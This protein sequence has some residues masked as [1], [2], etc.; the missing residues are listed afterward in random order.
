MKSLPLVILGALCVTLTTAPWAEAQEEPSTEETEL[1]DRVLAV[2]DED[3]ILES[4][5]R[6][7][8]GLGLAEPLPEEEPEA[9]RRRLLDALV[10]QKLRFHEIDRYGFAQIPL[11]EVEEQFDALRER[12]GGEKAMAER[13]EELELDEEG[14]RQLLARQLMVLIYVEERLGPRVL[15]G[16]A[17][18]QKYYD[19]TLVPELRQRRASVPPV[20]E[21]REE[22]RELLRQQRLNDEIDLWTEE[23]RVEADIEDYLD[24]ERAELPS[25]V[26][27]RSEG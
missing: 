12:M 8:I 25:A 22:I 5:L 21:V 1:V 17:D 27:D 4:D 23:L 15:I 6:R 11:D 10:E 19:E 3:P 24:S 2:V 16:L 26:I 9:F 7:V 14:V 18:I 13:L 20:S